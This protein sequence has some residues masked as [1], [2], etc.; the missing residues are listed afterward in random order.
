MNLIIK[1]TSLYIKCFGFC[2]GYISS[3]MAVLGD[4]LFKYLR[5]NRS[6]VLM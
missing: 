1:D 3:V 6:G 2:G 5:I 4:Q